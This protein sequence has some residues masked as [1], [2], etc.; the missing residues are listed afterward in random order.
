MVNNIAMKIQ[1]FYLKKSLKHKV[2]SM[3][4]LLSCVIIFSSHSF[5]NPLNLTAETNPRPYVEYIFLNGTI[6][7]LDNSNT[8]AEAIAISQGKIVAVGNSEDI[9]NNYE[10]PGATTYDLEG[11]A[12]MPGIIDGHTHLIGSIF[13]YGYETLA[14]GQ[15]IAMSYG[16]TTLNEKSI[17]EGQVSIL[18]TAEENGTLR[19]RLNLFP[20]HNYSFLDSN[21]ETIIVERFWPTNDPIL[22]PNKKVRVPGIKIYADG[23]TGSRGLPAMTIPYTQDMLDMWRGYDP[24]GD[25]YFNQSALNA[26]V[27]AIHDK[28]FSVAF[29]VMGDWGIDT[30]LNAIEYALAGADN[31]IARHQLEHNSFIREDQIAKAKSLNTVHSIRGYFPTYLQKDYET[32]YPDEWEEWTIN[33]YSLPS[34]SIH[35]YLETDFTWSTN[36]YVNDW[37][38]MNINPFLHMWSLVTKEAIDINGTLH[39]PDPWIAE[40]LLTREQALRLMTIEG[41]YAVKMENYIGTL[42]VDKYADLII[43]TDNPLTCPDD[44][45]RNIETLLTMINGTIEYQWSGFDFPKPFSRTDTTGLFGFEIT[46]PFTAII[47]LILITKKY[48]KKSK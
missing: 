2:I 3:I 25:L 41:A 45:I 30:V 16:Y 10:T 12:I 39:T 36:N 14:S 35:S 19:M 23:Y 33:R 8:I 38:S 20:I 42:E 17:D 29:H 13:W 24:Y 1:V 26:T 37:R 47:S 11:R 7:T 21:N 15:Q 34:E 5:Y 44:D 27:K 32:I 40:H 28:G 46:I 22:D 4:F 6:I 9:L 18:Q 31:D 43:T 48:S